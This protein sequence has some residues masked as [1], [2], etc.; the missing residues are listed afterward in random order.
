MLARTLFLFYVPIALLLSH[1][2]QAAEPAKKVAPEKATGQLPAGTALVDIT[3]TKFPVIVNG[4]FLEG[5]AKAA[6]DPLHARAL[7]LSNGQTTLAIVVVDSCMLP[8]ELLD[9]AKELAS[10]ATGIPT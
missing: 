3:P 10:K 5:S 6:Q 9:R 7:V 8:R 4:G 2:L 1:C